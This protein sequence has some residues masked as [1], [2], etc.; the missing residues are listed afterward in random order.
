MTLV[1][2]RAAALVLERIW[3]A[4]VDG[5]EAVGENQD[6]RLLDSLRVI[7][8]LAREARLTH[9]AS[10]WPVLASEAVSVTQPSAS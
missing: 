8:D 10:M 4:Q 9:Q 7:E 1:Q 3:D 2:Q 5:R 6:R